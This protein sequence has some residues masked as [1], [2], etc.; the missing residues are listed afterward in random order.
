M[1][2]W[3]VVPLLP[4]EIVI[5]Q[6]KITLSCTGGGVSLDTIMIWFSRYGG[7]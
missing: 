6:G 5:G 7:I 1:L 4:G 3:G 2:R